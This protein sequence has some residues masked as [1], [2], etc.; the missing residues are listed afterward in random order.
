MKITGVCLFTDSLC[1]GSQKVQSSQ[2]CFESKG[3]SAFKVELLGRSAKQIEMKTLGR[4][5]E[6][7]TNT[8]AQH[9]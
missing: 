8:K 2:E 3:S 1:G 7:S 9:G 5:G 4:S 6:S